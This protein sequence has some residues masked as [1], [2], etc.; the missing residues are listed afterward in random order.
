MNI[1]ERVQTTFND[2]LCSRRMTYQQ[3]EHMRLNRSDVELNYLFFVLHIQKVNDLW[4]FFVFTPLF[5]IGGGGGEESAD[6]STDR[7]L[8]TCTD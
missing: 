7:E 2:L 6:R 1:I 4:F 8:H 3:Y 5:K